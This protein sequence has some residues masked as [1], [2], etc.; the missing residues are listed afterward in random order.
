MPFI[1]D[2]LKS[3]QEK[4]L[5]ENQEE[6]NIKE[7]TSSLIAKVKTRFSFKPSLVINTLKKTIFGQNEVIEKV[8]DM[9]NIV[10]ADI[11][12]KHRPL[13]VAIF[14]GPTGVGKTETV[15]VIANSIYGR[16]D[17]FCRIDMNT[18]AQEHYAAAIT[19][20]PPGYVGSKEGT[21]VF[22]EEKIKGSFSKPGIVLLD[23]I[24][25]AD[26]TVLQSLLNVFDNGKMV[27]TNGEH[28]IDFRNSIIFMT[29]NLGSRQIFEFVDNNFKSKLKRL[30]YRLLPSNWG[31]SNNFILQKI[32]KKQL[33]QSF[34][35]EFINR[36][37]DRVIFNW[38]GQDT[39]YP[40]L[41][42]FVSLLNERLEKHLCQI[43]LDDSAKQFIIEKGFD[44]HYGARAMR[45]EIRRHLEV[46]LAKVLGNRQGSTTY[47]SYKVTVLDKQ[48]T[49]QEV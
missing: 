6:L 48:L 38:L 4:A 45:R 31:K 47:V 5:E 13:Y 18:L 19:G 11:T 49:F 44:K 12:E 15:K 24:E 37:D 3:Y 8:S 23:E 26:T 1:N 16:P 39:F 14:L 21:S 2:K 25:K 10:H 36:L 34:S 9:L 35:P 42:K 41:D 46:P 22:D 17:A 20:A 43:T 32:I 7:T 33:E 29:S 27:L 40:I 30:Y 28:V